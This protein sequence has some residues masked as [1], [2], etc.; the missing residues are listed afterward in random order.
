MKR[1]IAA[2]LA[3]LMATTAL[4]AGP[5]PGAASPDPAMFV[6]WL[7]GQYREHGTFNPDPYYSP[8]LKTLFARNSKLLKGEVG[9]NNDSDPVCQCQD[10]GRIRVLKLDVAPVKAAHTEAVVDFQNLDAHETVRL[11][12]VQTPKGWRIDDVIAREGGSLKASLIAENQRL[13]HPHNR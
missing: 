6:R 3:G 11:A 13:Q 12:L 5:A 1:L 2:A 4:A 9:D 8:A 7:Y 10:Y